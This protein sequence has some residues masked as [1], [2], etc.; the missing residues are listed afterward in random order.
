MNAKL[1]CEPHRVHIHKNLH[2]EVTVRTSA[3]QPAQCFVPQ[4][5]ATYGKPSVTVLMGEDRHVRHIK[6]ST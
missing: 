6:P 5:H 1:S 2:Y 4:A 3:L